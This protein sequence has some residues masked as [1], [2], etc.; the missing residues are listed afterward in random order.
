MPISVTG[1][2]QRK[3]LFFV[4]L[5]QSCLWPVLACSGLLWFVSGRSMFYKR[6]RHRMFLLANLLYIN[7]IQILLQRRVRVII[8][9]CS[10]DILQTRASGITK[11]GKY[12]TSCEIFRS[13]PIQ[14]VITVT[15][16]VQLI[17]LCSRYFPLN[18]LE[19]QK[20]FS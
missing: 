2:A 13:L 18:T 14:R 12:Y 9:W 16:Q 7:L 4:P 3:R 10:F 6:R 11:S 19:L 17:A 20:Y 15:L 8:K 1:C 5:V